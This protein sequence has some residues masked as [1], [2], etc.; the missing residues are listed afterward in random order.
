MRILTNSGNVS[1]LWPVSEK[2][3]PC[4]ATWAPRAMGPLMVRDEI[5]YNTG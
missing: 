1:Q 5:T 3:K 2:M 4:S